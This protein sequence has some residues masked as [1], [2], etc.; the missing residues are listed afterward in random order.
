MIAIHNTVNDSHVD[1]LVRG[2]PEFGLVEAVAEA[3]AMP[4]EFVDP[5]LNEVTLRTIV[6]PLDTVVTC[7]IVEVMIS[8]LI[9]SDPGLPVGLLSEGSLP[10]LDTDDEIVM[11][12]VVSSALSLS[13]FDTQVLG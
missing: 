5:R 4:A 11:L 2:V 8:A 6:C 3:L 1:G 7:M 9:G 12:P 10:G 13:S